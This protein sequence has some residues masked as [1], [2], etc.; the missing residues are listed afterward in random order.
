M[1]DNKIFTCAFDLGASGGRVM[2]GEYDGEKLSLSEIHRFPNEAVM[3]GGVFYWDILRLFHEMKVGLKKIAK[4]KIPIAGIGI[5]T[6]GVDYGYL[7]ARGNLVGAPIHYRDKRTENSPKILGLPADELYDRTGIQFLIFNT[8]YQMIADTQMRPDVLKAASD[9]LFVPDLLSYYLTGI[10]FNEYTIASTGQ[11]LNPVTRDWDDDLIKKFCPGSPIDFRKLLRPLV[12]PGTVIGPLSDEVLAE[13]GINRDA[14][15]IAVA[16]HDTGSAVAGTPLAGLAD[17]HSA[18][19]SCG[20]W[21]LFGMELTEPDFSENSRKKN[22][23]NEGGCFGTI[24]Y[25]KNINGLFIIQELRK[26]YNG[27]G[28]DLSFSDL[29]NLAENAKNKDYIITPNDPML[30][31]PDNME[32]AVIKNCKKT[33]Q[34]APSEIGE[35]MM[36]VYNG[37][38]AEYASVINDLEEL[39][40]TKINTLHIVG[41][42]IQDTLLCRLTAKTTQKRVAAGPVEASVLGGV[43]TQLIGL[44]AIGGLQEGREIIKNSFELQIY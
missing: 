16:T 2:I 34:G 15:F 25:L 43:V 19:L 3:A 29:I 7:D 41:G 42:G 1:A 5:D 40:Q 26:Y 14:K 10:K 35:I 33:G 12:M 31:N 44:G 17:P 4:E 37:L 30:L 24:R 38:A 18:Y 22:F 23:T 21:S 28:M 20:T 6:W 39:R 8:I 13:T 9:L 32:E 36:A 27:K 11:L